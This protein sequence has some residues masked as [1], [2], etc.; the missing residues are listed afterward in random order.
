MLPVEFRNAYEVTSGNAK[1]F[2]ANIFLT[3]LYFKG[4][5]NIEI[6][7][8]PGLFDT[9]AGIYSDVK[10]L[11]KFNFIPGRVKYPKDYQPESNFGDF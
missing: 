7:L 10:D 9:S 11:K 8:H 6:S 5:V 4:D 1:M 2:R 3:A